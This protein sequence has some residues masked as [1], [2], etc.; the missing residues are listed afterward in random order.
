MENKQR[1]G[2]FEQLIVWQKA[3]SIFELIHAMTAEGLFRG[4]HSL[5]NQLRRA[6]ISIPS[7]I[8]EGFG[9]YSNKEF[10][11]FLSIANG[12]TYEVQCQVKLAQRINYIGEKEAQ[13][14][15]EKCRE[16]SRMIEGLRKTI[17]RKIDK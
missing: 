3:A 5:K 2:D 6:S 7:N 15:I 1:A 8:A 14:L 16:I 12:S 9:R 13:T 17:A 10:M 4:D 11:R